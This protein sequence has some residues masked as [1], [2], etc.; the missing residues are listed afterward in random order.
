MAVFYT[1]K[2]LFND[3]VFKSTVSDEHHTSVIVDANK[4]NSLNIYYGNIAK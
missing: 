4:L 2:I 3:S 1:F